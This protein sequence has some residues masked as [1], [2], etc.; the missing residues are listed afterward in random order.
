MQINESPDSQAATGGAAPIQQV[1]VE[2]P[3]AKRD[4][5]VWGLALGFSI[6]LSIAAGYLAFV[7][8]REAR[9]LSYYVNE[10][11]GKLIHAGFIEPRERWSPTWRPAPRPTLEQPKESK[12]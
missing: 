10:V 8:G 7:N 6:T 5:F 11:D 1:R 3:S 9:M 4:S 2:S 12:P